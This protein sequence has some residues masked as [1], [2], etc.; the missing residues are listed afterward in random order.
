MSSLQLSFNPLEFNFI[1]NGGN[2]NFYYMENP[3]VIMYEDIDVND[4]GK[5]YTIQFEGEVV[6]K[7]KI[8]TKVFAHDLFKNLGITA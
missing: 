3:N 7:G 4:R 6:Y 8:K 2:Y 5:V 1:W